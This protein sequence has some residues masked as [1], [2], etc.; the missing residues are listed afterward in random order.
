[1]FAPRRSGQPLRDQTYQIE[2]WRALAT[3]V[4]DT[5]LQTFFLLIA[6]KVFSLGTT[7]KAWVALNNAPG[8]FLT[9][10]VLALVTALRWPSATGAGRFSLVASILLAATAVVPSPLLYVVG[11]LAATTLLHG[12]IPLY[13]QIYQDNYPDHERGKLFAN[14]NFIRILVSIGFSALAGWLLEIDLAGYRWLL[15]IYALALLVNGLLTCRIPSQPPR[16]NPVGASPFAFAGWRFVREDR[17][18]RLAL[19]SWMFMGTANLMMLPLRVEYLANPAY[20]IAL[21]PVGVGFFVGVVPGIARLVVN[22]LWGWLFDRFG[23][24]WLRMVLN[25]A[26]AFGIFS[27]FVGSSTLGLWIGAIIFGIS[28]SG[29]DVMWSLWVTKIAP[30]ERVAS[31]MSV[32]TFLTGVRGLAAPFLGFGLLAL[33]SMQAVMALALSLIIISIFILAPGTR[34]NGESMRQPPA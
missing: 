26:F 29:A 1:M 8:L 21:S 20:G 13:T 30:P 17:L 18:F 23:F 14:A 5:A 16:P 24:L 15:L 22:P 27:F 6:V 3:G 31:Y 10:V 34:W 4:F 9:P 12:C 19:I 32:H 25:L 33:V 2:R 11:C 7:G 28:F